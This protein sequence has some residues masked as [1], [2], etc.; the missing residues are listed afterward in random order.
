VLLLIVM[1]AG[2]AVAQEMSDDASDAL[3]RAQ[4]SAAEA[5]LTYN[6][7]Y[8]D[9][10][11]WSRALAAGRQ[12]AALAP[13]HPAPQ[14]FLAQAYGQVGWHSRAWDAWQEYL[15]LGGTTDALVAR[16]L[17]EVARWMGYHL[18]GQGQWDQ[19]R[20][21][22]ATVVQLEPDD[23]GA[24]E[25]LARIYL[26]RDEP[27]AALPHLEALDGRIR[28]LAPLLEVVQTRA[29]YGGSAVDTYEAGR[30]AESAGDL[31]TAL[32]RYAAAAR[33]SDAF[34]AAWR[35]AGEVS[36]ELG[37]PAEAQRYLEHVLE[38]TPG[39][40]EARAALA[41][42]R[43][44]LAVGVEA[45]SA[46][47][48]GLAAYRAGDPTTATANLLRATE[49]NPS[50]ATAFAWLGRIAFEGQDFERAS[51]WYRRASQ[52]DPSRAEYVDYV[53]QSEQL[54][55]QTIARDEAAA[56]EAAV[57]AEQRA[58]AEAVARAEAAARAAAEAAARAREQ[59]EAEARAEEAEEAARAQQEA[60]AEA[61]A[62]AEAQEDAAAAARAQ[63]EA[64]ARALEQEQEQARAQAEAEAAQ[65]RAD[66]EAE[67]E[68][69]EEAPAPE[70]EAATPPPAAP[71]EPAPP[72]EAAPAPEADAPEELSA[73]AAEAGGALTLVDRTVEHRPAVTGVSSA[74]TFF[75]SDV[76]SRDLG[77]FEGG[78]L[79]QR[80]EV[81]SKPSDAPVSYQVCLVP[82][83][84][85][86]RPACT[87]AS[88][89]SFTEPGAY[90]AEQPLS[91]L[92]GA[93]ALDL[94]SGLQSL[95]VVL[96]HPDGS[97]IDDGFLE[98][99]AGGQEVDI[100]DYFPMVVR[101]QAVVVPQGA[102]FPGW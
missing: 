59:A 10:P 74:V 100:A 94:R 92:S 90:Q 55:D 28:D 60:E 19:A 36:L 93:A 35:R 48:A 32:D 73:M 41:T 57:L 33:A 43:E 75:Y 95:M 49:A 8:P 82:H 7:H 97:P 2:S 29:R 31:H 66:A 3:R 52:L 39:D 77:A 61:R 87:E 88:R 78:V 72:V 15:E 14:R 16:Q 62:R 27:E 69:A 24:N 34:E 102:P 4:R 1:I 76:F 68:A 6:D 44:Q 96:R 21:Y 79:H 58:R 54:L 80:L 20:I 26:E 85:T 84:I 56:R 5:Q 37:L 17:M 40:A 91:S 65:A 98:R 38:M 50:Y 64:E 23:L 67:A 25:R 101:L 47:E 9:L 46:F 12:A 18:Y 99:Q 70:A 81:L 11:L 71:P 89:L 30:E 86:T 45:H 53:A 42:A 83:D 22:L 13:D 63:A 51:E